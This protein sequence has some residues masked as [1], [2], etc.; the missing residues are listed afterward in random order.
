MSKTTID[1]SVHVFG[2]K[3]RNPLIL[4]SGITSG[5]KN[6]LETAAKNG[7]GA[8]T[9]KSTTLLPRKGHETPVLSETPSGFINAVGITNPGIGA[10]ISEFSDWDVAKAGAPLIFNIA[11]KD[12]EEFRAIAEKI[13]SAIAGGSLKISALELALS[14]PHTPGY[15]TMAGQNTPESTG[16]IVRVV[17]SIIPDSVPLIAKLSPNISA[18]GEV[19]KAAERSGAAA[20]NMG[21]SVGPGMVIDIE[22]RSPVL[23]FGCGGLT[24]PAIRPIAVRC[25]YDIY[26]S[27]KIPI[28]GTGGVTYGKDAIEMLMAGASAVG[29]GTATYYRGAKAFSLISKEMEEWLS[30]H[31]VSSLSELV[32]AAHKK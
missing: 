17:R 25:V 29:V 24:G 10:A 26:Q 28:I 2:T 6:S 9:T 31:K 5:T 21:N 11:G 4:A 19:A 14:C 13:K 8:V 16:E 18:L 22:R 32:G 23:S 20:I 7:V 1:L 30:A 15:G 3:L 12:V 27:V